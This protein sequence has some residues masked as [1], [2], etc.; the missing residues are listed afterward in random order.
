MGYRY[1]CCLGAEISYCPRQMRT[2]DHM[3]LNMFSDLIILFSYQDMNEYSPGIDHVSLT[4][5]HFWVYDFPFSRW[6]MLVP[7]RVVFA[8]IAK[9]KITLKPKATHTCFAAYS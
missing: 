1:E 6:D 3:F 5:Q 7:W 4:T 2:T 8:R 9:N